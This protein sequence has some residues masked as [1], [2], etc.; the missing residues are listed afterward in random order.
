M[1]LYDVISAGYR[2]DDIL[3]N[4]DAVAYQSIGELEQSIEAWKP[5]EQFAGHS[6]NANLTFRH[7]IVH[8]EQQRVLER[9]RAYLHRFVSDVLIWAEA[10][11]ENQELLGRDYRIVIDSLDA[12][13]TGVGQE[14]LAALDN[15]RSNN[16]ANWALSALGCRNVILKL[17]RT[18]FI[19]DAE[20]YYSALASCSLDLKGEMEKNRLCAFI[21]Q[22]FRKSDNESQ[23]EFIELDEIARRIYGKGSQGKS[24]VRH[25]EAQQLMVDTFNLVSRLERLTGLEPIRWSLDEREKQASAH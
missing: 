20:T 2:L 7:Y 9:A 18:L 21:D 10:E 1:D 15:L 17:G 25:S 16:P 5:L 22:H 23:R 24:A 14:L 11:K 8:D 19:T 12:L 3:P 13:E 6:I 4:R